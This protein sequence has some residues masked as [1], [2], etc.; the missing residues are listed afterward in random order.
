MQA[1]KSPRILMT[2]L[3]V[4]IMVFGL[5]PKASGSAFSGGLV[6][7]D[8]VISD[9]SAPWRVTKTVEVPKGRTLRIEE[10]V[11]IDARSVKTLFWIQGRLEILGTANS[12]ISIMGQPE[13]YVIANGAERAEILIR[14]LHVNGGGKGGF[15]RETGQYGPAEITIE[16]SVFIDIP[17]KWST[18]SPWP[19]TIS[20]NVFRG[21]QGFNISQGDSKMVFENNLLL[22][23][24]LEYY[25]QIGW[26]DINGSG[27]KGNLV[28]R[29]N[30]FSQV[31]G[32]V[33]IARVDVDLGD[34]YWGAQDSTIV[35]NRILDSRDSLKYP[36]TANALPLLNEPPSRT[37]TK[38]SI[39]E[40]IELKPVK[41]TAKT[42]RDC[43]EL[44]LDFPNGIAKSARFATAI[45][46]PT[47]RPH[48]W[49]KGFKKNKRLDRN[50]NSV[51]CER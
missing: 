12:P 35:A 34:N 16:D 4:I 41:V 2:Y 44:R 7:S 29:G 51:V 1:R 13:E 19:V 6:T 17:D 45:A 33:A 22:G 8:L 43:R 5:V 15:L 36:G 37:P 9:T 14:F 46:D 50:G 28:I 39:A 40:L 3:T 10:G 21:T 42:Y 11:T 26:L 25:D 31:V 18:S 47:K 30:D 38:E 32:N 27:P 24:A 49:A 48:I 20:R 23:P